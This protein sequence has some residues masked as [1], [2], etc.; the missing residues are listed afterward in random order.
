MKKLLISQIFLGLALVLA[1]GCSS[2]TKAKNMAAGNLTLSKK[3]NE[4]V[5]VQTG[6]GKPTDPMWTSQISDEAL[7]EAISESLKSCG[8]FSAVVDLNQGDYLLNAT[9]VS[10]DQPMIGFTMRVGV[11]I[12]WSLSPKGTGKP[13]W[14]K[15]IMT[16]AEKTVGDAFA[17]VTR[18]RIATE[19][20]VQKN[21][22][23]ALTEL[24]RAELQS[25][26]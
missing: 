11:E 23:Q 21:I 14:E 8:L 9:I 17:G 19:A 1:T 2:A 16:R 26:P 22:G 4:T 10:L 13:V 15:A 20:A 12:A 25:S 24:S 3:F 5:A 6:G 18:L 7:A